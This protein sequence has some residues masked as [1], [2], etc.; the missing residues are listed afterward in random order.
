M[1]LDK[2]QTCFVDEDGRDPNCPIMALAFSKLN[3]L[4]IVVATDFDLTR[5]PKIKKED[6]TDEFLGFFSL[7]VSYA[8]QAKRGYQ[9]DL[10]PKQSL[11]IMPRTDITTI[12][13]NFAKEKLK[14]QLGEGKCGLRDIVDSVAREKVSDATFK[15]EVGESSD[16]ESDRKRKRDSQNDALAPSQPRL[17]KRMARSKLHV[18]NKWDSRDADVKAGTLEVGTWLDE[19][20]DEN[21]VLAAMDEIVF[22]GQIGGFGD[23]METISGSSKAYPI[24]EFRDIAAVNGAQ[25]EKKFE[26]IDKYLK[27]LKAPARKKA[28]AIPRSIPVTAGMKIFKRD[29]A[30]LKTCDCVGKKKKTC[31]NKKCPPLTI[32]KAGQCIPCGPDEKPNAKQDKCEKKTADGD[33]SEGQAKDP[34]TDTCRVEC[35]DGEVSNVKGDKCAKDCPQGEKKNANGD[36]CVV[37]C[38][39]EQI[40][41]SLGDKCATDCPEGEKKNPSGDR[42]DVECKNGEVP[43]ATNN[44]CAK[45][46]P[47]GQKKTA[48]GDH[49]EVDCKNGEIPTLASDKCVKECPPPTKKNAKGDKCE[50]PDSDSDDGEKCE[51]PKV[52]INGKCDLCKPTEKPNAKGDGCEEDKDKTDKRRRRMSFCMTV[53]ALSGADMGLDYTLDGVQDAMGEAVNK[54]PEGDD[55]PEPGDIEFGNQNIEL[56]DGLAD[57]TWAERDE[58]RADW[59]DSHAVDFINWI[60]DVE[61]QFM[62]AGDESDGAKLK[63]KKMRRSPKTTAI[64]RRDHL[65][66]QRSGRLQKRFLFALG[67]VVARFVTNIFTRGARGARAGATR[68]GQTVGEGIDKIV[69]NPAFR[70]CLKG[71]AMGLAL[72]QL[73]GK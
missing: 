57:G 35:K 29:D 48:A 8:I 68:A 66:E 17:S 33:C 39:K 14:A 11:P 52:K 22:D 32:K 27:D 63:P 73:H 15:W 18:G 28:R 34:I 54:W 56:P 3:K 71:V 23:A 25:I 30:D 59:A 36:R 60:L 61:D 37:D 50:S 13:K 62:A 7:I 10:G 1:S 70:D 45:D 2:I 42:C 26:D 53:V 51:L 43:N 38:P 46:C 49:C 31:D 9:I 16:S 72:A 24:F 47:T 5:F 20:E 40:S 12:Y 19:M 58:Q 65:I 69:K 41:N 67:R 21:E 44:K 55:L 6:L 4:K 64:A